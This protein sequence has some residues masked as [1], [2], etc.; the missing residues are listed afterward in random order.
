MAFL[1]LIVV[2]VA[3]ILSLLI[4]FYTILLVARIIL[5]WVN[6]D[7]SNAIV[8]FIYQSTE[9]VL[10]RVRQLLPTSFFQFG[11]DFSPILVFILLTLIET[12]VVG[13]LYDLAYRLRNG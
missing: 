9:P 4:N 1:G 8:R 13:G 6:P 10:M 2:A 11:F 3:K 5:S 7:P 12:I